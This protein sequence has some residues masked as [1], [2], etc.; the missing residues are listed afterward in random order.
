MQLLF[1]VVAVQNINSGLS[2]TVMSSVPL[3]LGMWNLVLR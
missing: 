1:V 3:E 2:L